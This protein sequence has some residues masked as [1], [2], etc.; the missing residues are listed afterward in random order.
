MIIVG[1]VIIGVVVLTII[2]QS[3]LHITRLRDKAHLMKMKRKTTERRNQW[4]S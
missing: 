3:L 4:M 1:G 2:A